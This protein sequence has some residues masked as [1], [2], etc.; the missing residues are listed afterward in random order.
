MLF[1]NRLRQHLCPGPHQGPWD[2]AVPRARCTRTAFLEPGGTVNVPSL[3]PVSE[4]PCS[5][6]EG[7]KAG[8]N[9][10]PD[11]YLALSFL[12]SKSKR[13]LFTPWCV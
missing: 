13:L 1:A 8:L 4:A 12:V 5:V 11:R 7:L 6:A 3:E 2:L 10:R 9:R